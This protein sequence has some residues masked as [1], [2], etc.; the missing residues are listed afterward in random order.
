MLKG[1]A[2]E[3][4]AEFFGTFILIAFGVGVVAQTVL[5][6][7]ANG[8]FLAINIGWGLAVMLGVYTAAGVSGAHLNP[9]VTVALALTGWASARFGY[10]SA[11]RAV[12]RNVGGGLLAMAVT[13]L[14]GQA[15]GTQI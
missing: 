2:R 15:L 1:T 6:K 4:A 11:R 7:S 14:I 12:L 3:A 5:S 13:H 8:S 10:G 9:A